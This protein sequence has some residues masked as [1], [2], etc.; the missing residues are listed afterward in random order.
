M[1]RDGFGGVGGFDDVGTDRETDALSL[2]EYISYDEM[3]IA[4]LLGV[5]CPTVT[6]N[7]CTI[8]L[9]VD[10]FTRHSRTHVLWQLFINNGARDN[11]GR[12]GDVG[13]FEPEGVYC[14]M[15]G[16]RFERYSRMESIFCF[17][18]KDSDESN[19]WAP[20]GKKADPNSHRT[21]L[22][23]L[24]ARFYGLKAENFASFKEASG[25]AS[26]MR[27]AGNGLF[28]VA[29]YKARMRISIDTFLLEANARAQAAGA[30]VEY[31]VFVCSLC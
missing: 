22:M 1:R 4:A 21:K 25:D 30:C 9:N 26:Y 18:D 7:F 5:S 28:N 23:H 27:L 14:G 3:A 16:A 12:P 31:V 13:T 24:W 29:L 19:A 17:L 11:R 6:R 20:Y 10:C 2:S 15:V 8:S